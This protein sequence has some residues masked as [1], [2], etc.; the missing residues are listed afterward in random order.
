MYIEPCCV[1]RQL[2]NLLQG[3]VGQPV[4]FQTSG[5]ITI[6]RF[7]QAVSCMVDAPFVMLLQ[8]PTVDS[9]TLNTIRYYF[10]RGWQGGL[11]LLTH[12]DQT[13]QVKAALG[14]V[15]DRVQYAYDPLVVDGQIAF[16]SLTGDK[17]KS[18]ILQG[19]MLDKKDFSLSLY[20]GYYGYSVP[21]TDSAKINPWRNA[22]EAMMA[23]LHTRPTI[24]ATHALVTS[25]VDWH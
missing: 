23:K 3:N 10:Q 25:V 9:D 15:I 7:M 1:D 21:G 18:V 2:P 16:A 13:E 20:T 4:F 19:A 24:K 11:L 17:I 6:A 22:T 8:V 14:D 5:D 12:D